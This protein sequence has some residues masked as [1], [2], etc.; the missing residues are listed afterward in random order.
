MLKNYLNVPLRFKGVCISSVFNMHL[1][2]GLF[3]PYRG[4]PRDHLVAKH[5]TCLTMDNLPFVTDAFYIEL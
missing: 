1:S 4:G 3:F 2:I 5:G